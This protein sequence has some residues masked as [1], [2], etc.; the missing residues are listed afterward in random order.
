MTVTTE[1]R[2]GVRFV[3]L[4]D[5]KLNCLSRPMRLALLRALDEASADS[6]C[7]AVVLMGRGRAFCAGADLNEMDTSDA[8]ADPNLHKT[9]LTTIES[10]PFPVIAAMHG[11][12]LG[13]GLELALGCHYRIATP[14]TLI[15]LPEVSLGLMPG[16][17]GTQRL[18]RAI[19]LEPAL[20]LILAGTMIKAAQAP[21]GLIDQIVAGDLMEAAAN[22]ADAVIDVRPLPR[23]RDNRITHVNPDGF[24]QWVR[25]G[26]ARDPRRLPGL[27]PIIEAISD[28]AKLP[29]EKGLAR[30]YEAFCALRA[31]SATLPFRYAFLAERQTSVMPGLNMKLARPLAK[32][33]VIGAGTMGAG[34]AMALV[35]AGLSALILDIDAQAVERALQRCRKD[36]TRKAERGR[37]T[38]DKLDRYTAALTGANTYDDIADC[39]LVIEAAAEAMPVKNAVFGE[40]DRVMK[41]GAILASNTSSLDIDQIA[42]ATNRAGDVLGLHFFNPANVMKL[43]EVIRGAKTSDET[44]AS[45]MALAKKMRKVPVVSGVCDGF[46]GNRMIEQYLRQAQFLVEEGATP[47]QVDRALEGFGMAMGPFRMLDIVGNDIPWEVRKRRRIEQPDMIYPTIPDVVCKAGWFGL[48]TGK[49]WYD[50]TQNPRKPA[51]NAELLPLIDSHSETLGLTRRKITDKEIVQRCILALVNEAAAILSEGVAQRGSD[52]DMAYLFGYGFP[53]FVGGPLFYADTIGLH[54]SIRAMHGF[55][56]NPHGDPAF[57]QPNPLLVTLAEENASLSQYKVP[58]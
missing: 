13:G 32:A 5:G 50:Y 12:A 23:L 47:A 26:V 38:Q 14:D 40:L 8:M 4:D 52:I 31:D 58:A 49:G 56:Q 35:E 29:A 41:P 39:D 7:R 55:A 11:S 54:A 28:A 46:I 37:L 42:Q 15:G 9:I 2:N 10:M 57:W 30:E 51:P 20:N 48:K 6:D 19:G 21:E 25:G 44:L 53:R 27:L 17:G 34:I 36:W 45:A 43:V 22:F 1:S 18:P 24:L 3:V 16:A 33:A